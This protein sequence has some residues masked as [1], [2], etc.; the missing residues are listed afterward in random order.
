MRTLL[1]VLLPVSCLAVG[2]STDTTAH[3]H[4]GKQLVQL[5]NQMADE[6]E[7]MVKKPDIETVKDS[8]AKIKKV[9]ADIE[10]LTTKIRA[11]PNSTQNALEHKFKAEIEQAKTRMSRIG[12]KMGITMPKG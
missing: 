2:C 1:G 10:A 9:G 7:N 11:L 8:E 5:M 3:D 4:L 6:M 12:S